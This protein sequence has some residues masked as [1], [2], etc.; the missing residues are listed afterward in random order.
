[1]RCQIDDDLHE[2]KEASAAEQQELIRARGAWNGG[3]AVVVQ[4]EELVLMVFVILMVDYYIK[5]L[6]F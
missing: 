2:N 6:C 5:F 3:A 1:M 4:G